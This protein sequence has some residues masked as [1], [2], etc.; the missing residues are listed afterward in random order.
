MLVGIY[1]LFKDFRVIDS[2]YIDS[3]HQPHTPP[4]PSD[5]LNFNLVSI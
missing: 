1:I 3:F 4:V 2:A 5:E